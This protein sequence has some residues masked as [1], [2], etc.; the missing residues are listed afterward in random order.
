MSEELNAPSD[1][2]A[3]NVQ[4]VEPVQTEPPQ[5]TEQTIDEKPAASAREA[6]ERAIAKV[7]AQPD[8]PKP[9]ETAD[10]KTERARDE[11]GKFAKTDT[12]TDTKVETKEAPQQQV[13]LETNASP[14]PARFAKAA[15][16]AWAKTPEPVRQE[17]ERAIAELTQGIEKYKSVAEPVQKYHDMATKSGTTL[18]KAL[19]AYVGIETLWRQNPTQGFAEVCKNMAVDPRQMLQAIA[20]GMNGQPVQ[21]PQNHEVLALRQ[22]LAQ[23][24]QKF[25][26]LEKTI[27][28][29]Q[30]QTKQRAAEQSVEAFA[31][32]NPHFDEVA[33]SIAQ[34]LET[35]FAKDLPDA[36]AKSI[37]LNPDVLAKIEAAKTQAQPD[38]AQTRVKAAK[39]ITGAPSSGS[40]PETR[41]SAGS[42][43]E[44]VSNAFAQLGLR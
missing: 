44:A 7:A 1:G 14:P 16:D 26:S 36:Y 29:T 27:T 15:Q 43:R 31:K 32:E 21:A 13:K 8:K 19:D 3:E 23:F 22:Q 42:S 10:E 4:A 34:M 24:E 38:A 2:A 5:Q 30:Q 11:S 39:S 37:R 12:K 41:K 28:E 17:T 20:Q 40:A 33:D 6:V 9:A 25:G 35:G 18:E